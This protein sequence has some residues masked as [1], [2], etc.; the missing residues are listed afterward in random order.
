MIG[1]SKRI[2]MIVEWARNDVS[3]FQKMLTTLEQK[4]ITLD[5]NSKAL[6]IG[7]GSNAP[8]SLLLHA[9]GINVTG[10]DQK[11]G[12]R[13][14]LGFRPS[15]YLQYGQ[16]VGLFKTARKMLGELVYDRHYYNAL[17]RFSELKLTE[18]GLNLV[19]HNASEL[20]IDDA[21][22]DL[23]VSNAVW[24]HIDK[25]ELANREVARILKP[26]GVA[27]IEIHLFPSLSGG[28]DLPWV[29]PG[30]TEMGGI[31]PWR[32][33]RDPNWQE[34]V[35][36]NR[37]REHQ[38]RELFDGVEQLKILDWQVEFTE[39]E[40]LLTQEILDELPDYSREELTRRSIIVLL[41]KQ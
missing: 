34:P 31:Q 20:P 19:E 39:G 11:V 7:C 38:Y 40:E 9:A 25:V 1:D 29:V 32:H 12:Y 41:R 5:A 14:G 6:D 23:V 15:R 37:L 35:Y 28:H 36:L 4:G 26:G 10:L 30:R 13:W 27:Y 8:M 18:S 22:M 3:N 2:E 21:S 24:E 16:K 33:L 17:A